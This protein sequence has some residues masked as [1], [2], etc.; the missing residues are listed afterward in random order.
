MINLKRVDALCE[1]TKKEI[2]GYIV[3]EVNRRLSEK[4]NTV[5]TDKIV[6]T[7]PVKPAPYPIGI[8]YSE[9]KDI[10]NRA[11]CN[12]AVSRTRG[13]QVA[14]SRMIGMNRNTVRKYYDGV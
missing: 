4:T 3:S 9:M 1:Q 5:F 8:S 11:V 10:F 14:A 12:Y 6:V 7:I 2:E 13:N